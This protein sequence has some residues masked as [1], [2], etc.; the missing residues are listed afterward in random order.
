[1]GDTEPSSSAPGSQTPH[2]AFARP[3]FEDIQGHLGCTFTWDACA[4]VASEGGALCGKWSHPSA[5][6]ASDCSGHTV[7]LNPPIHHAAHFVRHYQACKARAPHN[8]SACIVLPRA[9]DWYRPAAWAALTKGMR[10][11]RQYA[12]GA[13]VLDK[14]GG[15]PGRLP[16]A[17]DVWYDPPQLCAIPCAQSVAAGFGGYAQMCDAYCL[18]TN[19]H[20]SSAQPCQQQHDGLSMVFDAQL[21]GRRGYTAL[22]DSGATHVFVSPC[23]VRALKLQVQKSPIGSVGMAE[24]QVSSVLGMV[25]LP[26]RIGRYFDTVTAHVLP[27]MLPHMHV[28]LGEAWH[29]Q[30]QVGTAWDKCG[31]PQI[32]VSTPQGRRVTL[33]P[34]A[35]T[36]PAPP[37]PGALER[38][39]EDAS[40]LR[41]GEQGPEEVCTPGQQAEGYALMDIPGYAFVGAI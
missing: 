25:Q 30:V 31:P 17:M 12:A 14:G 5:F 27:A 37:A 21:C 40:E 24:A 19:A 18:V 33:Q 16:V 20:D 22:V 6:F 3:E 1:M 36:D 38:A 7:W 8:T 28:I 4:A 34:R 2:W 23:V 10:L 26:L 41:E 9:K 39:Q 35:P 32:K 11:V 15:T 29:R 13:Q